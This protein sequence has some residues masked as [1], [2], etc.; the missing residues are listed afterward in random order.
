MVPLVRA[1]PAK[2]A[3]EMLLTGRPISARQ[4]LA[5]GLVNR[6]VPAD[7]LD[8]AVQEFVDAIRAVSPE[9]VRL[10]KAAFYEQRTLDE[11]TAYL[12]A[13]EVMTCNALHP[14]AQEGMRAF[15]EKRPP[16][17]PGG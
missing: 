13:T 10:G 15:L 1:V 11:G 6:V 8:A 5:W 16:R 17:W 2:A 14:E 3:L 9:A 12:R 7:Q 4:A